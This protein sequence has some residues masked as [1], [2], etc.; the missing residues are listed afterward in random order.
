MDR[1]SHGHIYRRVVHLFRSH[2]FLRTF[3]N[4]SKGTSTNFSELS[5][6]PLQVH[7]PILSNL[8]L[9]HL[10]LLHL[11]VL[12]SEAQTNA[13]RLHRR[14]RNSLYATVGTHTQYKPKLPLVQKF[15]I[16]S[17]TTINPWWVGLSGDVHR[18]DGDDDDYVLHA[19]FSEHESGRMRVSCDS[20]LFHASVFCE[21]F[22]LLQI[23]GVWSLFC[24]LGS[25]P[26]FWA[27]EAGGWEREDGEEL[28][29]K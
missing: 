9:L 11:P 17:S 28:W 24:K 7:R 23:H 15:S 12:Q 13:R 18:S 6:P 27:E 29:G 26:V 5:F 14:W 20:G 16:R 4:K 21:L 10:V 22:Y 3:V 19:P 1:I 8:H 25:Q 2:P